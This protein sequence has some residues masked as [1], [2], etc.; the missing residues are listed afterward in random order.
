VRGTIFDVYVQA[1]GQAWLLLIEGVIEVCTENGKCRVHDEPG[2][3]IRISSDK[4]DEPVKWASLSDK[5]QVPFDAAFPFVGAAPGFDPDPIFSR[6]DIVLGTFDK[7]DQDDDDEAKPDDD[8]D[9]RK[10]EDGKRDHKAKTHKRRS[11]KATHRRRRKKDQANINKIIK[12]IGIGITIG[13]GFGGGK[14]PGGHRGGGGGGG[15]GG[16]NRTK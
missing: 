7:P 4:V 9:G 11:K 15:G 14:K 1:A 3:L 16:Y 8:D 6:D 2:K 13:G 10:A 5:E 12:G